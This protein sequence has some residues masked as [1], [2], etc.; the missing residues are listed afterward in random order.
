M[1]KLQWALGRKEVV[2]LTILVQIMKLLINQMQS[3]GSRIKLQI[4]QEHQ[5]NQA[6]MFHG[7]AKNSIQILS[8]KE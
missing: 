7:L 2:Q 1:I 5:T 6:R 4:N 8:Q 3:I